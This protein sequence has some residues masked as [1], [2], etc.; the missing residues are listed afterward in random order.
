MRQ[1]AHAGPGPNTL[2]LMAEMS[3]ET[4]QGSQTPPP[5]K[6][7]TGRPP[8]RKD[9]Q[10]RHKRTNAEVEAGRSAPKPAAKKKGRPKGIKNG[11][12]KAGKQPPAPVD[13]ADDVDMDATDE[14]LGA[15]S[16]HEKEKSSD[17]EDEDLLP[18]GRNGSYDTEQDSTE[19]D[20][21]YEDDDN[22]NYST[23]IDSDLL[24]RLSEWD[25]ETDHSRS[26]TPSLTEEAD[27]RR[28]KV[29]LP[30]GKQRILDRSKPGKYIASS[31]HAYGLASHPSRLV[32]PSGAHFDGV[33]AETV[34]H[35]L[36]LSLWIM[37]VPVMM[38]DVLTAVEQGV[39][40]YIEF[41]RSKFV[42]EAIKPHLSLD[43]SS[44][45]TW[46]KVGSLDHFV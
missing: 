46:S 9:S 30:N 40:P 34:L 26:P 35:I 15:E 42:P 12:G 29:T 36:I 14:E 17:D 6:K 16:E 20:Y 33:N 18:T 43:M 32:W 45:G 2:R 1:E 4:P 8:G 21:E 19:P 24:D 37:R 22:H 31:G 10:P 38:V 25:T 41:G 7:R 27:T 13:H 44:G 3:L 39:I 11:Q 5:P 28:T 23:R